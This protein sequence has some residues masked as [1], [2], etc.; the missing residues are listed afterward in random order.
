M[1]YLMTKEQEAQPMSKSM[2]KRKKKLD[3]FG[4]VFR[5]I[6]CDEKKTR[7]WGSRGGLD[8]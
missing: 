8:V 3:F 1:R 2:T 4:K 5:Y 6:W 7:G